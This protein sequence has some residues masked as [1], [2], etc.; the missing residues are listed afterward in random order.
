MALQ[1]L[2]FVPGS[3]NPLLIAESLEL[4]PRPSPQ[5]LWLQHVPEPSL[6]SSARRRGDPLPCFHRGIRHPR[7]L[8]AHLRGLVTYLHDGLQHRGLA[9]RRPSRLEDR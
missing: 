3:Q 7:P 2:V 6:A 9:T 8:E 5:R 1:Q 4:V